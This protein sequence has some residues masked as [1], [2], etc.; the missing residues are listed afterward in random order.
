MKQK[1]TPA[2]RAALLPACGF[3]GCGRFLIAPSRVLCESH[4]ALVSSQVLEKYEVLIRSFDNDGKA[5]FDDVKA[6]RLQVVRAAKN[7]A[8]QRSKQS[9]GAKH[10][11]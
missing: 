5:T 11:E 1:L 10:H 4:R 6:A 7:A 9:K 2:Q 8:D 3:P